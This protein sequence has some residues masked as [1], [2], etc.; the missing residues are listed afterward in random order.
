MME[1]SA[2]KVT[3]LYIRQKSLP[4]TSWVE[5]YAVSDDGKEIELTLYAKPDEP[6]RLYFGDPE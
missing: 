6:I 2:H 1:V 4:T 5:I 3:E